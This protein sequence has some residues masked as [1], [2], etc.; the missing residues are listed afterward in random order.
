MAARSPSPNLRAVLF[1]LAAFGVFATHD[2]IIKILGGT[3]APPQILFYSVLLSFPLVM[4]SLMRDAEP[5]TLIPVHPWWI[6]L[7]TVTAVLTGVSAFY[8]FTVLPLAE[9]YAIIFASPLLITIMA[10]PVLGEVV[11]LRRWV[12]VLI[13]LGGVLIVL[14]PGQ[15]ELELG[16]LAALVAAVCSSVSSIIVRRIGREERSVVLILYPMMG[17]FLTMACLLPFIY[18]P[19]ELNDLGLLGL[20]AVLAWL[21]QRLL[22][23]AYQTGEAVIVAPMQYSQILWA[24]F[25]GILFFDEGIDTATMIGSAIII[26]S[27]LYIALRESRAD[28]SGQPVLQTQSRPEMGILPRISTLLR[29][30]SRRP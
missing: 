6:L 20:L 22:I 13:G 18:Q 28:R 5:G 4:L 25:Y 11:R 7:R 27:G 26:A 29:L 3:Y 9:V 16:H 12:A 2:V 10:I 15:A 23:A 14:R 24:A 8:A 19:T 21:A 1:A 30:K 17:N